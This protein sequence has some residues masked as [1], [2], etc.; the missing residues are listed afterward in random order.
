MQDAN[1]LDKP[2]TLY[3]SRSRIMNDAI[4][5]IV[6]KLYRFKEEFKKST[7]LLTGCSP[8]SGTTTIAINLAIALADA[9]WNTL[10][11]DADM[12]KG[13]KYKRLSG[14]AP[15]LSDY[16]EGNVG[17]ESVI[18]HTNKKKLRYVTC[19]P[20][21]KDTV[22]LLCSERM[23]RFIRSAQESFDFVVFD[24]PSL[25]IVPDATVLFPFVDCVALV[26][27]LGG[28]TKKQLA[29]AKLETAKYEEKYAGII[30]NRVDMRQYERAFPQF[31]YFE[32]DN[33]RRAH[34]RFLK[35]S[36]SRGGG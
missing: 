8:G 15:G 19:G 13:I 26:L 4:D 24:C 3:Q 18:C 17:L 12:R 25:T 32:E 29:R 30:V 16:L 27:R 6:I 28:A 7:I 23:Q 21:N 31:D 5:R 10:L 2:I 14:N 1:T 34:K 9:G 33:I 35:K 36:N 11:A 20:P 22:R